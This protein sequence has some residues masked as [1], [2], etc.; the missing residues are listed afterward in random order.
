MNVTSPVF[1]RILVPA[2]IWFR[3]I[4]SNF[5]M[6][7]ITTDLPYILDIYIKIEYMYIELVY[8]TVD[9]LNLDIFNLQ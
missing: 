2:T 1:K 5:I 9:V 4:G 6:V 7:S 8:K 3:N